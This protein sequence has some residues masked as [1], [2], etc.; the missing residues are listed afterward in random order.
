MD[1]QF[2]RKERTPHQNGLVEVEFAIISCF[3][4]AIC[5]AAHMNNRICILVANA[6]LMY[7]TA[8]GNL[9][10]DKDKSQTHYH[11]MGLQ[12]PRWAI[13]GALQTF[14]EA[15]V[16]MNGTLCNRGI[17]VVFVGYVENHS[18]DCYHLWNPAL[19]KITESCDVI[20]LHRM[21]YQDDITADMTMLVEHMNVYEIS[22]GT[23]VAM[24]LDGPTVHEPSRVDLVKDELWLNLKQMMMKMMYCLI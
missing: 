13:P 24:K 17:P 19:H 7:S 18:H 3:T 21:N 16:V 2:R 12:N 23:I 6:V 8:L 1:R 5:N 20:W 22:K 4:S 9:A 14:G 10:V 11:L 15:G